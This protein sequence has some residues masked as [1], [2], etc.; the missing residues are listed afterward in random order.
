M[1]KHVFVLVPGTEQFHRVHAG[2]IDCQRPALESRDQAEFVVLGRIL[3]PV[4]DA[5]IVL[6]GTAVTVKLNAQLALFVHCLK[7]R[8]EM[9]D[10]LRIGKVISVGI[11]VKVDELFRCEERLH[12]LQA[13]LGRAEQ[14]NA[15]VEQQRF[16]PLLF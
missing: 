7:D 13:V 15:R 11:P 2:E 16:H 3:H 6:P 5:E 10:I 4:R 14:L 1:R 8:A 12:I 9:F